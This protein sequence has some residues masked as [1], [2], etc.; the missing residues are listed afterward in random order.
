MK[1]PTRSLRRLAKHYRA[2]AQSLHNP[3]TAESMRRI[4]DDFA[5][6]ATK[7]EAW[8]RQKPKQRP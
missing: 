7:T 5:N 3:E 6:R 2:L 8:R 4:A 1:A